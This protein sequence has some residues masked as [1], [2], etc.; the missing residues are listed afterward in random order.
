MGLWRLPSNLRK[1]QLLGPTLRLNAQSFEKLTVHE[2]HDEWKLP[3]LSWQGNTSRFSSNAP[4]ATDC[5][6]QWKLLSQPVS[7]F[8]SSFSIAPLSN[9]DI[10]LHKR[11][12]G[13]GIL[14]E[15]PQHIETIKSLA[16]FF[17]YV[18]GEACDVR[19]K[20]GHLQVLKPDGTVATRR[21]HF[22]KR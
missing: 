10:F 14:G 11:N 12:I 2:S 19:T 22:K 5:G 16:S 15:N 9:T 17:M 6:V 1:Y 4:I 21:R 13:H 7:I 18:K 20:P 3:V 8:N